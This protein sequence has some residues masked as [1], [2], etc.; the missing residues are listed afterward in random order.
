MN[1][2]SV[3]EE[4]ECQCEEICPIYRTNCFGEMQNVSFATAN[5]SFLD[6]FLLSEKAGTK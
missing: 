1:A 4:I 6:E 2:N 5:N 3:I